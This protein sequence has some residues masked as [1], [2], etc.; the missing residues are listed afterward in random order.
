[1]F[2][3][4]KNSSMLYRRFNVMEHGGRCGGLVVERRTPERGVGEGGFDS[5]S[6]T[7]YTQEEV[8]PSRHN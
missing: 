5:H 3:N 6:S 2:L 8:A 1:M 7:G 4:G